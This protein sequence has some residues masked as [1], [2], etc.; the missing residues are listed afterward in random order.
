MGIRFHCP[1]GH[2]LN[3]KDFL[4]GQKGICPVCGVKMQ[5]PLQSTRPSSRNPRHDDAQSSPSPQP[6]EP[7]DSSG[8]N[9]FAFLHESPQEAP[10]DPTPSASQETP[11]ADPVDV[12]DARPV[13]T[14]DALA[15]SGAA[16]WFVRTP[17]GGQFGPANAEL[18][19]SWL[20]EGRIGAQSL[21]W[22]ETWPDWQLAADVFPRLAES[23]AFPGLEA[24][25][26]EPA[27]ATLLP[28]VANH[29]AQPRRV[30]R[31]LVGWLVAAALG[32]VA[33]LAFI[34]SRQSQ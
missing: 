7:S 31:A 13:E 26:A 27:V 12:P 34:L 6:Q 22:C 33:V 28:H 9:Q 14:A 11:W 8:V 16:A 30:P 3:V 19:R 29:H 24:I 23:Q 15:A 21:V 2:K 32:L 25:V 20:A 10:P 17:G 5:I 18:M 1:N 4:A